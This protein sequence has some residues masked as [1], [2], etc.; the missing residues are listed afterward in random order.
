MGR[1]ENKGKESVGFV[2][3]IRL[4][5]GNAKKPR[6]IIRDINMPRDI[7]I[8]QLRNL[9]KMLERENYPDFKNNLT[10]IGIGSE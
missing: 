6:V 7:V 3:G 4:H 2:L 9:V 8:N 10:K 5:E 1:V